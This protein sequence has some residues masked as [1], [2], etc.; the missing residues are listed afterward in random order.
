MPSHNTLPPAPTHD[1]QMRITAAREPTS[2]PSAE[3][4]ELVARPELAGPHHEALHAELHR[5]ISAASAAL[6]RPVRAAT[7]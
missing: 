1:T 3:L 2:I 4:N 5:R 6:S 7:R